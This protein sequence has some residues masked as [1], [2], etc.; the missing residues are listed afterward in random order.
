MKKGQ[1]DGFQPPL[2]IHDQE[3]HD[4]CCLEALKQQGLLWFI[5]IFRFAF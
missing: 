1:K 4:D 3:G 5:R 2:Q